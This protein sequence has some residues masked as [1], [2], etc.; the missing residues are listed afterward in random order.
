M[1]D[2]SLIGGRQEWL[3]FLI[4]TPITWNGSGILLTYEKLVG[5]LLSGMLSIVASI[6]PRLFSFFK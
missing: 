5:V 6:M 4:Q 3:K 2:F 1:G